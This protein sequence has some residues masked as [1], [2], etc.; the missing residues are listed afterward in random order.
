MRSTESKNDDDGCPNSL[1]LELECFGDFQ[2]SAQR[3]DLQQHFEHCKECNRI[4]ETLHNFYALL[5]EEIA[6]PVSNRLLDFIKSRIK[7]ALKCGVIICNRQPQA[8][9]GNA[10]AYHTNLVFA[11]NGQNEYGNFSHY[12]LSLISKGQIVLRVLQDTDNQAY[13]FLWSPNASQ[14]AKQTFQF[15]DSP[16][17]I[18]VNR[19][20]AAR[21]NCA[22]IEE[23][24]KKTI[25]FSENGNGSEIES[26][27]ARIINSVLF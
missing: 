4:S 1:L 26:L 9:H 27:Q 8:D 7:S 10:Q 22:S 2:S 5:A 20:G 14:L 24:D 17:K 21:I 13:I 11:T 6:K 18:H 23:L 25:Y 19:T 15:A 12:D 3:N 16:I